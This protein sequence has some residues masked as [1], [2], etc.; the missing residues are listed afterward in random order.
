MF[1]LGGIGLITNQESE[2]SDISQELCKE[3]MKHEIP[4]NVEAD[5]IIDDDD[6][7]SFFLLFLIKCIICTLLYYIEKLLSCNIFNFLHLN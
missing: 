5:F 1:I 4:E 7:V 6:P 2:M 3:F